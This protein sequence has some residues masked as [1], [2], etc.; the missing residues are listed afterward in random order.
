MMY[1]KFMPK[2]YLNL[3]KEEIDKVK[4]TK[5]KLLLHCCC[6]PFFS[7]VPEE[8]F[9][10]FNIDIY[11]F[12]PNIYPQSEYEKRL[13]NIF[14]VKDKLKLN[15]EIIISEYKPIQFYEAIKGYEKEKERGERCNICIA[16]RMEECAIVAK[17]KNYDYF[18]TT[19]TSSPLKNADFINKEGENL[20]KKY[21]IN[22][23]FSDFKKENGYLKSINKC[24]DLNI[25]RQNY[26][27]CEFSVR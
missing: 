24:K 23:L 6:A 18:C 15:S 10:A 12:N 8:V 16:L 14:K 27:G 1:N 26:C 22:Y 17:E 4:N 19:L 9:E 21:G 2:N 7:S 11:Y 13:D 5:P 25:Y 20:A 3:M